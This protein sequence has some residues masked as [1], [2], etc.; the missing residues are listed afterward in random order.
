MSQSA[1]IKLVSSDE[2]AVQ[3]DQLKEQLSH[4][5]AQLAMTGEQL[6]W[7]YSDACFPYTI[8]SGAEAS[9]KWFYLKGRDDKHNAIVFG[10]GMDSANDGGSVPYIQV[11]LPDHATHADKSKANEFCKYLGKTYKAELHLFN[12][13]TMFYNPRK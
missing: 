5:Q 9:D 13:R 1:Y 10:L 6:D 11:V 8:E 12:G 7:H 3:L 2:D 4:Y